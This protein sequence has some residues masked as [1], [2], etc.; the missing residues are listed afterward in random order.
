[1][2]VNYFRDKGVNDALTHAGNAIVLLIDLFISAHPPRFGHFV[3]HLLFGLSY[4]LFSIIYTFSGG[5]NR[6]N[7][8]FIYTVL[9]WK[10]QTLSTTIFAMLTLLFL[11]IMHFVLTALILIRLKV[12]GKIRLR[13]T[14]NGTDNSGYEI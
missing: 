12:Y 2:P 8:P 14:T 5:V 10:N 13:N 1:M 9:D 11:I 4:I 6:D 3:Y 7:E